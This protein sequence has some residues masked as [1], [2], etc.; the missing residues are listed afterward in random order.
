MQFD[1]AFHRLLGSEGGYSS[2]PADPGGAT[3]YGISE[4][5]ARAAGYRGDMR[6]L[7][8]SLAQTIYRREYWDAVRADELPPAL[9]YAV[10]DAAVNSGVKQSVKWLQRSIGATDDGIVGPQTITMARAAQPDFVKRRMLAYRLKFMTD[11]PTWPQF[12]RGW[13]RRIAEVLEEA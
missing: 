8:V 10:F 2:H 12:S 9:R 3:R 5:V 7:P 4:A 1:E 11:L 13:A 6:N